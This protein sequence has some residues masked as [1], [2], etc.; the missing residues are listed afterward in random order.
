MVFSLSAQTNSSL[1]LKILSHVIWWESP[2][3]YRMQKEY[4]L[5]QFNLPAPVF[6]DILT[7]FGLAYRWIRGGI[8]R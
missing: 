6:S 2:H 3:R 7:C 8:V 5:R 4:A 1:G